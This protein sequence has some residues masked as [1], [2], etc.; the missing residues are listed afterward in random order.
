MYVD[1]NFKVFQV[2]SKMNKSSSS[3]YSGCYH[4]SIKPP[5]NVASLTQSH[6]F[7]L[8]THGQ[9]NALT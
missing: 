4:G 8:G 6:L 2:W 1:F 7:P 3:I 9:R 5:S